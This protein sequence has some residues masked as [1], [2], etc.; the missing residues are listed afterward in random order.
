MTFTVMLVD[1]AAA[2][3]TVPYTSEDGSVVTLVRTVETPFG[4]FNLRYSRDDN[5]TPRGGRNHNH[6]A[7]LSPDDHVRITMLRQTA[8]RLDAT[9]RQQQQVLDETTATHEQL[10]SEIRSMPPSASQ[11]TSQMLAK[12]A[13]RLVDNMGQQ[14]QA[15]DET[16]ATLNAIHAE[17]RSI[18]GVPADAA[19]KAKTPF[20]ST[21]NADW[22]SAAV[23]ALSAFE[24][25]V[26]GLPEFK[27]PP[28]SSA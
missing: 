13:D 19:S 9:L 2:K 20:P 22:D 6:A 15:I 1:D 26:K 11:G 5:A 16:S 12:M 21:G 28:S 17:I 3:A 25:F 27:A 8:E 24:S 7:V 18:E 10:L 14:R 4:K 23:A